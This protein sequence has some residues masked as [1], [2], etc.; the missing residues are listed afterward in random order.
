VFRIESFEGSGRRSAR[1]R[2]QNVDT[3]ES[4]K[5]CLDRAR[6]V[7]RVGNVGGHAD[8]L[9]ARCLCD[10]GGDALDRRLFPRTD[11][12]RCAFRREFFRDGPAQSTTS[13]GDERDFVFKS[14]IHLFPED[15]E[16]HYHPRQRVGQ[17]WVEESTI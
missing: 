12:Q 1:V 8:N 9:G 7:I 5:T 4:I 3:A 15:R 10:F 11:N 14:E 17:A 6:D 2:N 13:G 16:S